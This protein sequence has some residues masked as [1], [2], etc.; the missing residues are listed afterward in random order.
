MSVIQSFLNVGPKYQ[1]LVITT[2]KLTL[3]VK[4]SLH[5]SC[6]LASLVFGHCDMNSSLLGDSPGFYNEA[7]KIV[8]QSI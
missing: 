3:I 7:K 4:F 5:P 2:F 6:I 1:D 8:R